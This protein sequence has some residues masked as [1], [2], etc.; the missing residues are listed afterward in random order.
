MISLLKNPFYAGADVYGKSQQ[1]TEIV[2]GQVRKSYRRLK[3]MEEWDVLLK[4]HHEGY[5]DWAEFEHN[6]Q[7]IATNAF[8]KAGGMKSGRGGRGLLGGLLSC[9]RCGRTMA[10]TYSGHQRGSPVYR[11]NQQRV[12]L[13]LERCQIF[14]GVR[15]DAAI[16]EEII[17]VVE[18]MAIEASVE[19]EH[20]REEQL[21]ER[22]RV[23]ELDLQQAR[24]EASLAER[25]YAACDPDNR[26]IAAQLEK[27]WEATL[28]RVQAC[29]ARLDAMRS[30]DLKADI[31]DLAGLAADLR[32]AWHAPGVSMRSR[33]RIVRA[34]IADIVADVE[35][36]AQQV[37][38][39]IHWRGGQHSRLRVRKLKSGEHGRRTTEEALA[40][41]ESMAG[42]WSDDH[43][44]ASLNRMGMR[45]GQ[46]NTWTAGRVGSARRTKGID[47]YLSA[48][49]EGDWRTMTEAASELGVT[50]HVIRRLIKD[51]VLPARHLV[52]GAPYQI[53]VSDLHTEN[54]ANALSGRKS[55]C[56]TSCPDQMSMF[57]DA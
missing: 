12:Q 3:P 51:G 37:I 55:P 54:V 31:P 24:Y 22:Q 1:R 25:R 14:G 44:A 34:L 52:P 47:G 33:Q 43:I 39:T 18:P 28:Q 20:M 45:T 5:I 41:M 46:D 4:D 42:R 15:V 26:L 50:R 10:V 7:Q 53:R 48:D 29:E 19:A 11:C 23:A 27:S 35:D 57:S 36:E 6:Q 21:R 38:L 8:S 32:T 56:H 9:G 13:G 2:D 16:A 17:R 30:P 40:V 49:K